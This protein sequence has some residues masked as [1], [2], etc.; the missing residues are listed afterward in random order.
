MT[1]EMEESRKHKNHATI[2]Q[3]QGSKTERCQKI[4]ELQGKY[5]KFNV[6]EKKRRRKP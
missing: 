5:D 6:Q 4:E 1:K 3:D 2:N